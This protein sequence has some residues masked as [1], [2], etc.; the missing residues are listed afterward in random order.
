MPHRCKHAFQIR[1][2]KP[3]RNNIWFRLSISPLQKVQL[4][5]PW[6]PQAVR[7]SPV[8]SL[9]RTAS[10][11]MKACVGMEKKCQT[12]G[13]QLTSSFFFL[14]WFQGVWTNIRAWSSNNP[15]WLIY[16]TMGTSGNL[17]CIATRSSDRA[18]H[19]HQLPC[20]ITESSLA[21][22]WLLES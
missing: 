20:L 7:R 15:D 12:K 21:S 18:G 10:Q 16:F 2:L 8:V 1:E 3:H 14:R 5:S 6:K 22:N 9:L 17:L 19:Q 13:H 11:R 4:V